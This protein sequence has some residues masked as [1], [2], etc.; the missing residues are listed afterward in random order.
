MKERRCWLFDSAGG[1]ALWDVRFEDGDVLVLGSE[2]RGI[3]PALL[4]A[5]AA[6]VVRIPQLPQERCLNLASAAAIAT[7]EALR[8]L[9]MGS[10]ADSRT[11]NPD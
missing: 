11:Q 4:Q 10:C 5:R 1:T 6:Q 8:Q 2:T 3:D 7:Y 9:A